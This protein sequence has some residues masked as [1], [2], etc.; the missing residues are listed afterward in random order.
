M[1][2][3]AK[4]YTTFILICLFILLDFIRLII[5]G[6]YVLYENGVVVIA[7][8]TF[9]LLS[10]SCKCLMDIKHR[11]FY[12]SVSLFCLLI[13]AVEIYHSGFSNIIILSEHVVWMIL[14]LLFV[15]NKP[16]VKK[17]NIIAVLFIVLN[18]FIAIPS[19]LNHFIDLPGSTEPGIIFIDDSGYYGNRNVNSMLNTMSA[20]ICLWLIQK[21]KNAIKYLLIFSMMCNLVCI[22]FS[23]S[24]TSLVC[25]LIIILIYIFILLKDFKIKILVLVSLIALVIFIVLYRFNGNIFV[26]GQFEEIVNK[27]SSDRYFIWKEALILSKENLFFGNGINTLSIKAINHFGKSSVLSLHYGTLTN[28]HNLFIN[29]LYNSGIIALLFFVYLCVLYLKTTLMN[30]MN[31]KRL[32]TLVIVLSG[33]LIAMLDI[34]LLYTTSVINIIWWLFVFYS[35]S[36]A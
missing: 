2:F 31:L 9:I 7:S 34:P 29:I 19:V 8:I 27:V 28:C 20:M 26:N 25:I 14:P 11:R 22:V 13:V 24:R 5:P 15:V 23:G 16:N 4:S 30:P 32:S 21:N 10:L 18:L 36:E 6:G 1:S 33:F 12:I 3:K 35:V 17:L